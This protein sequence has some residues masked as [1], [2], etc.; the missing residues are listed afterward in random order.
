VCGALLVAAF[1]DTGKNLM[2]APFRNE[3]PQNIALCGSA[4]FLKIDCLLNAPAPVFY[5]LA[6]G[7]RG[8]NCSIKGTKKM[9]R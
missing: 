3:R 2:R 9:L 8:A 6:P 5:K 7:D 1:T 4:G